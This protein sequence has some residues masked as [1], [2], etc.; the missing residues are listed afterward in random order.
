[1]STSL[2]LVCKRLSLY[3]ILQG[4][5]PTTPTGKA[6]GKFFHAQLEEWFDMTCSKCNIQSMICV[7]CRSKEVGLVYVI[8]VAHV[9]RVIVLDSEGIKVSE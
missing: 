1:M 4:S 9:P 8:W 7:H 5:H 2:A 6:K 3:Q